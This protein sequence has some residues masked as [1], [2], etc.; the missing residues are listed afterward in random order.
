MVLWSYRVLSCDGECEF[1][2]TG[3]EAAQWFIIRKQT[4][5][6][7]RKF[8]CDKVMRRYRYSWHAR[9][10][11]NLALLAVRTRTQLSLYAPSPSAEK[12][13]EVR[14]RLDPVQA[15]LIPAHVTLCREDELQDID[16][17]RLGA[18]IRSSDASPIRMRFGHPV[19]FQ[20]HGILLPCM[21]GADD[22]QKLRCLVLGT[23]TAR[24]HAPH[25]TLAHPRN[26]RSSHNTPGSLASIPRDWVIVFSEIMHILQRDTLP[27]QVIEQ[28]SLPGPVHSA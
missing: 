17:T 25:I 22:F 27:W 8:S 2:K 23:H 9:Q 11:A 26:P 12:L 13:D 19:F 15:G 28:H 7:L 3:R 5:R 14:R 16:L 24:S 10:N 6:I 4:A 18:I 1:G 21:E 20:G